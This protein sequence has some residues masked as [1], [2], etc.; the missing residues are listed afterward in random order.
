MIRHPGLAVAA[1]PG[2]LVRHA[3]REGQVQYFAKFEVSQ[4][5]TEFDNQVPF[6]LKLGPAPIAFSG[7]LGRSREIFRPFATC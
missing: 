6:F 1:F 2:L 4:N 5:V 7:V 3:E